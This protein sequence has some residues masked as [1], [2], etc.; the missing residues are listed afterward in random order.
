MEKKMKQDNIVHIFAGLLV[1]L[2]VVLAVFHSMY[3]LWLTL[4]VGLN[5]F[6]YGF[7]SFCPLKWFLDKAG[8]P[9]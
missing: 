5:L 1:T 7:T 6:Q 3:W 4:F 9:K 2:S 8:V